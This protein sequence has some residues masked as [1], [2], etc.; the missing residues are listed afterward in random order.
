MTG[1]EVIY[2]DVLGPGMTLNASFLGGVGGDLRATGDYLFHD[3]SQLFAQGGLWNLVRVTPSSG[4]S[5]AATDNITVTGVEKGGGKTVIRGF[6]S[7]KPSRFRSGTILATCGFRNETRNRFR[8]RPSV[9]FQALTATSPPGADRA[10]R[11]RTKGGE[12][13]E[14]ADDAEG[15]RPCRDHRPLK[16][17]PLPEP[18]KKNRR[19]VGRLRS[20]TSTGRSPARLFVLQSPQL[21]ARHPL[22]GAEEQAAAGGGQLE[23][24]SLAC[25][26]CRRHQTLHRERPRLG[27]VG[28]VE[29]VLR[30]E[31]ETAVEGAVG[32]GLVDLQTLGVEERF[33]PLLG[34]VAVP[35]DLVAVGGEEDLAVEYA[36]GRDR[37][38]VDLDQPVA[39]LAGAGGGAVGAP[40]LPA[41]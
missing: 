23:W 5:L 25:E 39:E 32:F 37:P 27:A 12:I 18:P 41:V 17:F 13:D 21:R 34:T 14:G 4:G 2:G 8:V 38:E 7:T 30:G 40:Q 35:E 24:R 28:L 1:S 11:R 19:P 26:L 36:R 10:L 15:W 9:C 6:V 20:L 31:I 29:V 33:R 3:R 22:P 16:L